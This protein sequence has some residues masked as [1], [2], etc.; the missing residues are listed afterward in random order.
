MIVTFGTQKGGV[1]KTTLAV[2]FANYLSIVKKKKVHVF[3]FDYQKSFYNKWKEDEVL[4]L[5]KL[6][7]VEIVEDEKAEMIF[8]YQR[9]CDMSA[10]EDIYIVDLAG[11]LDERYLDILSMSDFV[12]VPFEYSDVSTKSTITFINI[13]LQ[14][15][16][17]AE[18][19]FIRSRYDK[20]YFYKN[21]EGMDNEIKKYGKIISEPVY[22]RNILQNI[23]TRKLTYDQKYAVEEPFKELINCLYE[24]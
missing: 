15:E 7:D 14:L 11:T 23:N 2:A 18:M 13:M 16:S 20:G 8:E 3:D 24:T 22:K 5:P 10:S 17:S 1:G 19:I 6:Y 9:I 21:Q 12:V 4:D